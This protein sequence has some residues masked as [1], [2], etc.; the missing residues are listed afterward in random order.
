MV[1][2]DLSRVVD[3]FYARVRMHVSTRTSSY[4][5]LN[6]GVVI[7]MTLSFLAV[8]VPAACG[9][10]FPSL[11]WVPAWTASPQPLDPTSIPDLKNR[12]LR[13]IVHTTVG[14]SQVRVRISNTFGTQPLLIGDAHVAVPSSSPTAIVPGSDQ[15]LTF[16]G[17]STVTIPVGVVIVSDPVNFQVSALS[18][19][20]ISL[21]L[22][23]HTTNSTIT[24]HTA[25]SQISYVSP[26]TGD[27]SG[28]ISIP[29]PTSISNWFYL[30]GV[31][32][33]PFFPALTVVA[34]GDSI[35]DGD[36]STINANNRWTDLLAANL[37]NYLPFLSF[38]VANQGISGNALLG[39]YIGPNALERFDRD[40]LSQ[41]GAKYLIVEE[42]LNDI[43][44]SV[45]NPSLTVSANQLIFGLMQLIQ[46]GHEQ[47]LKVFIAT[48]TPI[49]G[50]VY[51]TT[52]NELKRQTVNLF[53]RSSGAADAVL[54]FD[55]AVR[56]PSNPAQL[57]AAYDSGDHLHPNDAGYQAIAASINWILFL[58]FSL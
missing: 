27:F 30:T 10:V 41:A 15:A 1:I 18:N 56:D 52:G 38:P 26:A 46:R 44:A 43:G 42:G 5:D 8:G 49:Q 22:P 16:G 58:G 21:Y 35:T 17:Q 29:N 33:V 37:K 9:G 28:A 3:R 2:T 23:Q 19:L 40:V 31:E 4:S 39:E 6:L 45:N 55:Q 36:A 11:G 12:T 53:I 51:Y 34:L 24:E 13:M 57:L 7:T 47:S 20:A 25:A 14:G 32:V 50:S 54:D 48:L